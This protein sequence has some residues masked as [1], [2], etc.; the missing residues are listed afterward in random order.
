MPQGGEKKR[1][2]VD[3]RLS[4][5]VEKLASNPHTKGGVKGSLWREKRGGQ[6]EEEEKKGF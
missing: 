6:S 5:S 3:P 2:G 1:A 4:W